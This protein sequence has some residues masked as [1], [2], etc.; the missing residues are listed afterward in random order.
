MLRLALQR[1]FGFEPVPSAYRLGFR[2]SLPEVQAESRDAHSWA[3]IGADPGARMRSGRY[4]AS[5]GAGIPYR[6][7]RAREARAAV[8]LLHGAFDYSAAFDEI[9][10]RLARRGFTALAFDQR[11]FGATASRGIWSGASRMTEDTCEAARFLLG[12]AP[13]DLPLFL[14]GES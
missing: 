9:G 7:W 3:N 8:L 11:G 2:L 4:A 6:L 12:R 5:D 13:A 14:L 1:Y 10:P